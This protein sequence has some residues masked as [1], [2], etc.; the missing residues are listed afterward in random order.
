[1]GK[2]E[3]RRG[4]GL[5]ASG[6]Q[7]YKKKGVGKWAC[8]RIRRLRSRHSGRPPRLTENSGSRYRLG[9]RPR[10]EEVLPKGSGERCSVLWRLEMRKKPRAWTN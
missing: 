2:I 10:F 8:Q 9:L 5:E 6:T 3:V 7:K 4:L 1:M